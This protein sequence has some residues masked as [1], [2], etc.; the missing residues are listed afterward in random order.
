MGSKLSISK[1]ED[2]ADIIDSLHQT[3]KYSTSGY[4][5]VRCVDLGYGP[6][7]LENTKYVSEDVF[8]AYSR[9]YSPQQG[10]V[11]ITRVGAN[12]GVTSYVEETNFCLG[13]NTAA[14][15]PRKINPNYL[16]Y[17]LNSVKC[18]HQMSVLVAGAAQPTLSLKAI[19]TLD[20]PRLG[21]EAEDKIADVI[22]TINGKIDLNSKTNQTLELMA[23]TLF[24]SWFV[25]F[26]P[27]FDNLLAKH[28][29]TLENLPSDFP[30]V[31]LPKAAA[32]LKAL[33]TPQGTFDLLSPASTVPSLNKEANKDLNKKLNDAI[34]PH[35]PSEFEHNEQLGWLPKGWKIKSIDEICGINP[36]SWTKK[37]A[38]EHVSYVDLANAKNGSVND[39]VKYEFNE[40]PSRARRVL[41]KHDTIIGVVRPAN[42]SFAYVNVNG[43]T[44]STGFV[45][46]RPKSKSYR[47]FSY[48]SLTN[49]DCISEFTRIADGAA[50]PAI[51]PD[52][53]AKAICTFSSDS[54]LELFEEMVCNFMLKIASNEKALISLKEL[55]DTLL[56][57]LISGELKIPD[58]E[59]LIA[60]GA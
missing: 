58:A 22:G 2:V 29:F 53:V 39:V 23:Q 21:M 49:D 20:I 28:D 55:R 60:E 7:N 3:P 12:F 13:Q 54:L 56:P 42:R 4:P 57:K 43:L 46:V 8:T 36:E 33:C 15:V 10:D 30:E 24:K 38:P 11:I 25:D 48:L 1:L 34:H 32:R 19:K 59:A 16:Y 17:I 37:T 50:Y 41:Q 52:D 45:V 44:G 26:D 9:R 18:R 35:F 14:I 47:V 6:L 5:M 51:K 40:A 27:V 31:L